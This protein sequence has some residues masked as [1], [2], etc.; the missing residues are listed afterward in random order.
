M[1]LELTDECFVFSDGRSFCSNDEY[2]LK[3]YINGKQVDDVTNY[4]ASQN[5]KIL[6]SYGPENIPEMQ[7]QL[8]EL[9]L[10]QII[11]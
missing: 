8:E 10:Q 1:N 9:E 4:V 11:S 2:M 6:I 3:F 7:E 5:D